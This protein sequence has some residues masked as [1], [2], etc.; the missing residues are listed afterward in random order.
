MSKKTKKKRAKS[1]RV[2]RRWSVP[3]GVVVGVIVVVGIGVIVGFRSWISRDPGGSQAAT[4]VTAEVL[5][6]GESRYQAACAACHGVEGEGHVLLN[7]PALNGSE[8]SWHHPD[9]QIIGLIR[10]GG[11]NMP[12]VGAVW[13]QEEI[14]AVL[15]YFKQWWSPQQRRSQ[16]GTI[17]E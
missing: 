6:V 4:A 9:E 11:T 10:N 3:L 8:H 16:A 17:G 13:N 7:A 1:K 2:S 12:P 5:Q 15:A 14:D